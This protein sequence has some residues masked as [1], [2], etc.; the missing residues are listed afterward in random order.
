MNIQTIIDNH[1]GFTPD[2]F[3]SILYV[4]EWNGSYY[5][6]DE[7]PHMVYIVRLKHNYYSKLCRMINHIKYAY[8]RCNYTYFLTLTFSDEYLHLGESKNI[9][10]MIKTSLSSFKYYI[11]NKDYG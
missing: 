7:L 4:T 5:P 10:R 11:Y 3:N 8:L 6:Y 9:S 1:S 2:Y